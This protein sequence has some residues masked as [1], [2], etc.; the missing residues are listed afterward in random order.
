M[1]ASLISLL[2]RANQ[3]ATESFSSAVGDTAM[4]ARQVQVLAAIDA[5]DG[6]SQTTLVNMTGV[7]R[8]TLADIV[9]RL[10]KN[11]LIERR[12]S[13][14]DARAYVVKLTEAGKQALA[15]GMPALVSVEKSLL[16]SLAGKERSDLLATLSKMVEAHEARRRA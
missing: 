9:R 14:V 13:K 8:S 7:D 6:P 2:H 11:K 15:S 5:T 12:R 16:A 4:T 3:I 10:Q 1:S